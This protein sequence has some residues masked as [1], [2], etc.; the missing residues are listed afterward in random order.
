[1]NKIFKK[2]L[3][4]SI[5]SNLIPIPNRN[6]SRISNILVIWEKIRTLFIERVSENLLLVF[7]N[8][9]FIL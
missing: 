8:I 7:D 3:P 5:L 9:D 1:M 4:P 6:S 2:H